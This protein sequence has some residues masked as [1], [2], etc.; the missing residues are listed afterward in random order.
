MRFYIAED[1]ILCKS[2]SSEGFCLRGYNAV[3][4]D[5][6]INDRCLIVE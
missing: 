2:G 6:K 4:S 5:E 1:G 3:W